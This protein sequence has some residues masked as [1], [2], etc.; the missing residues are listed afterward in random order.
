MNWNQ[1]ISLSQIA[2]IDA[3]SMK[4]KVL[5]FKHSTRC[6]TSASCLD[7]MERNWKEGDNEKIKPYY[8]D[9]LNHRDISNELARHYGI[10]HESPQLL[11]LENGK[12]VYHASHFEIDYADLMAE[13]L[14]H[15][16]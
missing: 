12:C 3:E 5:I 10:Y 8:L 14:P 15:E 16:N 9:L 2:D 11:L 1:L 6:S 7:R 4:G 13:A